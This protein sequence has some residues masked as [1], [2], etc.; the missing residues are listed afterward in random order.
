MTSKAVTLLN[1]F[2]ERIS[3]QRTDILGRE[4]GQTF[5]R[6][7]IG[8][9]VLGFLI[10]GQGLPSGIIFVAVYL[11]FSLALAM[12]TVRSRHSPEYRRVLTNIADIVALT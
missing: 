10:A 3:P 11:V 8:T 7:A 9:L 1:S 5:L 4:Q 2:W 12:V 6:I